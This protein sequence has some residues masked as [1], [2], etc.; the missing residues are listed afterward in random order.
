[1]QKAQCQ[2]SPEKPVHVKPHCRGLPKKTRNVER[3]VA[4]ELTAR[5]AREIARLGLGKPPPLGWG[6]SA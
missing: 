4:A 5:Y 2:C 1:M 3:D 6:A